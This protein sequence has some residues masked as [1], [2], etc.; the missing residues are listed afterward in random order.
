MK[1]FLLFVFLVFPF[2]AL[3]AQIISGVV[4]DKSTKLPVNFAAAYFDGTFVATYTDQ[5]GFFRLNLSGMINMHLTISSL[6]YYSEVIK[7]PVPGKKYIIY[8]TPK[9]YSIKEVIV[10][11]DASKR[12]RRMK[13]NIFREEFLGKSQN[14]GDC[15]I[16]NEEDLK[17]WYVHG[18][19]TVK[20]YFG[21]LKAIERD[22][23]K[24]FSSKPIV[25]K[26]RALGYT[27]TYF[28]DR[29]ESVRYDDLAL[30]SDNSLLIRGNCIFSEDTLAS[31]AQRSRFAR[32][33]EKT[34]RGSRMELFRSIWDNSLAKSGYIIADTSRKQIPLKRL[35]SGPD[36]VP[37]SEEIRY[38]IYRG[39]LAVAYNSKYPTT[40]ITVL[41]DS[42]PFDRNHE[43]ANNAI[44]WSGEMAQKRIGDLLPFEYKIAEPG[45]KSLPVK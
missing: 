45:I 10:S 21:G 35:V 16:M 33:R 11:G 37:R 19:D 43:L 18:T 29:F 39:N 40:W 3:T 38:L 2:N 25:I 12:S 13:L 22:T 20:T 30:E 32:K 28:I 1:K 8:L 5:E 7:D 9:L 42:I 26:N 36:S 24:A 34:F 4:Y 17:L 14:A 15:K 6:G 23:L 41:Y 44:I 31:R 27:L